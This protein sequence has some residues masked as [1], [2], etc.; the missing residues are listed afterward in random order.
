VENF[1]LFAFSWREQMKKFEYMRIQSTANSIAKLDEQLY[2]LGQEGWE[3]VTSV[4][5]NANSGIFQYVHL[6]LKRETE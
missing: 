4:F 5:S 1:I 6:I 2:I 3:L